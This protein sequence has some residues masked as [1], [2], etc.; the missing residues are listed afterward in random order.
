LPR[1]NASTMMF[2]LVES[3]DPFDEGAQPS[4]EHWMITLL[5]WMLP[6]PALI[7]W[8]CVAS[9]VLD[10]WT[11]VACVFVAI[12]LSAWRGL[13]GLPTEGLNQQRQ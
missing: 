2:M 12:G 10:G 5:G 1:Y 8:L 4:R 7:V 11:A 6:W 3:R 13:R 9:R